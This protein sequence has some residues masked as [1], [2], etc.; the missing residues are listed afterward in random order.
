VLQRILGWKYGEMEREN[1]YIGS[2]LDDFLRKEGILEETRDIVL[3]ETLAWQAQ[4]SIKNIK[5]N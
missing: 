5:R 4:K 2:S 3:K 1:P